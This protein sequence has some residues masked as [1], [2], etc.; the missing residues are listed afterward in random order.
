MR[1]GGI[2]MEE[3]MEFMEKHYMNIED[4]TE[5][6]I[7]SMLG[8]DGIIIANKNGKIIDIEIHDGQIFTEDGFPLYWLVHVWESYEQYISCVGSISYDELIADF[9]VEKLKHYVA[10]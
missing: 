5:E 4:I 3:K 8:T 9:T 6:T 10:M 2:I 1:N 7:K